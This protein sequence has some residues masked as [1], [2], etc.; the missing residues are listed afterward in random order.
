[1]NYVYCWLAVRPAVRSAKRTASTGTTDCRL[2]S[3]WFTDEKNSPTRTTE[4][5][6]QL[7]ANDENYCY[8]LNV[9]YVIWRNAIVRL[10]VMLVLRDVCSKLLG[11]VEYRYTRSLDVI[12]NITLEKMRA[13]LVFSS[14]QFKSTVLNWTSSQ[15]VVIRR[16]SD[17][18]DETLT[19]MFVDVFPQ[20]MYKWVGGSSSGCFNPKWWDG[21]IIKLN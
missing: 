2:N 21:W 13:I 18:L 6:W 1:M 17:F 3:F 19:S 11:T 10:K 20:I 7:F 4:P 14:Y 8:C 5:F 15:T 9:N 12:M 16:L